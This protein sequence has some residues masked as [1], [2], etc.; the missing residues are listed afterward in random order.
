MIHTPVDVVLLAI[1]ALRCRV[2]IPGLLL[3]RS[4]PLSTVV[5]LAWSLL[6]IP[7]GTVIGVVTNLAT[8]EA[9]VTS[10]GNRG[11]VPHKCPNRSV[12]TVL[13]EAGALH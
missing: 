2:V 6:G 10:S 5:E 4:L 9:R 12:L 8:S 11:V 7:L 3:L 1:V 13:R